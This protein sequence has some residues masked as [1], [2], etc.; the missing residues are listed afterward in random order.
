MLEMSLKIIGKIPKNF[1]KKICGASNFLCGLNFLWRGLA[2]ARQT[3]L[4]LVRLKML[5]WSV[6]QAQNVLHGESLKKL[7]SNRGGYPRENACN[8]FLHSGGFFFTPTCIV[9]N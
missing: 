5:A 3:F 2:A 6:V 7:E 4:V 8:F 1:E 9:P